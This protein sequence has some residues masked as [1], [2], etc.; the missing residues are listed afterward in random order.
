[1][2]D[3]VTETRSEAR[4]GRIRSAPAILAAAL[5]LPLAACEPPGPDLPE[6]AQ[7]RHD[8]VN[9]VLH[10]V[11]G[12]RGAWVRGG[13]WNVDRSPVAVIGRLDGPEEYT[14]GQVAGVALDDD[15]RIWVGDTQAS[16]VRIF[17]PTGEFERRVGRSGEGPGEFRNISGLTRAPDGMA[18]LDGQLGRVTIFDEA[19]EVVRSFRLERPYMILQY[20][21]VMAFDD[22][23]RFY[24]QGRLSSAP[25]IDSLGVITY[26]PQGVVTDTALIAVV[27]EDM[28][29]VENSAGLPMMS[30]PR[31]YAPRS[32]MAIGPDGTTYFSRGES[33]RIA[34]MSPAGDTLRVIRRTVQP[35]T[36]SAEERDSAIAQVRSRF[37]SAGG[38]QAPRQIEIPDTKPVIADLE[39]DARGN[40]WVLNQ[41]PAGATVMEWSVH[42]PD[43]RY[44]GAIAVPAMY[45]MDIGEDYV[46]GVRY[47]EMGVGEVVVHRIT[48]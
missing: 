38:A 1:M 21:A 25:R 47:G 16:E 44:L 18:V 26:S 41:P 36:V 31:P 19:G 43:G 34:V 48:R 35:R 13:S 11:S 4:S 42:D 24:D 20:D 27:E 30:F 6:D 32:A 37:E 28:L 22:D 12:N 14:L 29:V 15:G 9:G 8:T 3:S 2:T 46:A 45:V 33:Y 7:V 39:V 17:S 40:L 23:G 5:L 10:V